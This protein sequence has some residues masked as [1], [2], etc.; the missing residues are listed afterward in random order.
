MNVNIPPNTN[1]QYILIDGSYF[2]FYRVFALQLWWKHAKPENV[3]SQPFLNKEFVEKFKSTFVTK[4]RE[5]KT[6]LKC[7]D[8]M[9]IVGKDCPRTQIWRMK[10][11]PQYKDG[12]SQEKNMEANISDFFK[13]VYDEDLFTKSGADY[14]LSN[15][16]LEADDCLALATKYI[17]STTTNSLVKIIT[18]DHDYIQL[19]SMA[20]TKIELYNMKYKLLTDSNT[21]SGDPERELFYKTVLGDKSDNIDPIFSKCGS[22]TVEKC[23][24]D[25]EYFENKLDT[26][27]AHETYKLN[28]I[29]IDFKNIPKIYANQV[30]DYLTNIRIV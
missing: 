10:L 29:L 9:I 24:D 12:R 23:Y 18:S 8:A 13:L 1:T 26:E 11:F 27:N 3:L 25:D 7:K 2:I 4:I 22:K 20:P 30:Y 17:L 21:Y 14:I 16:H 6:K 5:L 19:L 15:E 28:G